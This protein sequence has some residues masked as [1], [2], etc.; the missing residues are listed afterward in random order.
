MPTK[1]H[2]RHSRESGNPFG[3]NTVIL[4]YANLPNI[5]TQ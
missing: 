4:V 1:P 3:V 2:Y 5:Q